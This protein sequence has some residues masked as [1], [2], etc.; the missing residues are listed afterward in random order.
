MTY[1]TM[2]KRRSQPT[3][4][5]FVRMDYA[6]LSRDFYS[7]L[8]QVPNHTY[9]ANHPGMDLMSLRLCERLR[10]RWKN[11]CGRRG[12]CTMG[13]TSGSSGKTLPRKYDMAWV[14]VDTVCVL[15]EIESGHLPIHIH[16]TLL[17]WCSKVSEK[18][19][20]RETINGL[21]TVCLS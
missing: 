7:I 20:P 16:R 5:N 21:M 15:P 10:N 4:M 13:T 1:S 3:G 8:K 12:R 14:P 11:W 18:M 2:S 9:S 19:F 17:W 6:G